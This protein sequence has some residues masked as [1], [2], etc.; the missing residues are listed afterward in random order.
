MPSDQ[1]NIE[2]LTREVARLRE[3]VEAIARHI[4]LGQLEAVTDGPSPEIADAIRAGNK[5]LAIKLQREATGESLASAKD[6]VEAQARELG[7]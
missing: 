1:E 3:Q 6:A 4:G 2:L 5:I 7:Y